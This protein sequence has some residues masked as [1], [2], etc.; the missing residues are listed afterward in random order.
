MDAVI[1]YDTGMEFSAI[2]RLRDTVKPMLSERGI[3]FVELHPAEPFLYSMLER[4]VKNRDGSGTHSGYGWCGGPCRW[5]TAM[6]TQEICRYKS[7]VGDTVIDY[8]GIAADEPQRFE[9]AKSEGKRLPLVEWG[10]TESDCLAFCRSRGYSWR[11]GGVDLYDILDRVSCWCCCNKNVGELRNMYHHLPAYWGRLKEL[12]CK[13][14]RPM[15]GSTGSIFTLERRFRLEDEW[16]KSGRRI[17]TKEF[18]AEI[19]KL[20]S[21]VE[22]GDHG[23]SNNP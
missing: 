23:I 9:K 14:C 10:M 8:V 20:N 16:L 3:E 15:K 18:Y 12:Q 6:K 1:F 11:E 17:N 22:E 7:C 4:E 5:G 21:Q 2:Y 19:K 13:I